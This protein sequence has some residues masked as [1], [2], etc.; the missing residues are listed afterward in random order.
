MS[1]TGRQTADSGGASSSMGAHPFD[2]VVLDLDGTILDLY[3]HAPMSAVVIA[4]ITAVQA[5]GIPVTVATGRTLDYVREH[6]TQLR[7]TAPVVT[8][9]GAVIGDPVSGQILLETTIP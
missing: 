8:T 6:V 1:L 3:H 2:L 4:A 9:Q 7:L 5:S